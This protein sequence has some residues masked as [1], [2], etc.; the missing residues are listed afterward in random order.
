MKGRV[1]MCGSFDSKKQQVKTVPTT[2]ETI[3]A[4][5]EFARGVVD[6]R[7]G[8]GFPRDFDAWSHTDNWWSYER[9]RA[10]ATLVPRHVPLKRDGKVTR[11]AI[12]WF[13]RFDDEI[14]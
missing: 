7:T 8:R 14:L 5:A 4:A 6:V 1:R 11:E 2:I 12:R 13:R 3:M 10:W 9:G